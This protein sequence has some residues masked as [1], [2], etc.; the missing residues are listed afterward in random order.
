MYDT[1]VLGAGSAGCVL[2]N[3]LS[4]DPG[5]KVLALE[6]G[7]A[8]PQASDIPSDWV[9]MFNTAADWGFYTRAAAWLPRPPHFLAA[10]PH[11][12]RVGGA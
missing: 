8:A 3:R 12:R 11:G 4:A 10:R 9:T 7:R 1:I 2:A 6:A 5:R